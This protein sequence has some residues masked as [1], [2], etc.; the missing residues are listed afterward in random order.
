MKVAREVRGNMEGNNR[1]V[2][3]S[4]GVDDRGRPASADGNVG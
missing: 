4:R 2:R 3:I 1:D